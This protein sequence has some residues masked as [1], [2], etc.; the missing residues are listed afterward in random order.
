MLERHPAAPMRNKPSPPRLRLCFVGDAQSIHTVR[1]LRFFHERGHSVAVVSAA[2]LGDDFVAAT[3]Y[4]LSNDAPIPGTRILRNVFELRRYVTNFDPDVLH[5]HYINEAGWLA[6]LS[7]FHPFVLTAWGSDVYIAPRESL[8]AKVMTPYAVRR[9][10]FVTA[11]SYDQIA[12]LRQMGARQEATAVVCWGVD[13]SDFAGC[14]RENWRRRHG[15]GQDREVILSPR[16][17][18]T[19]SNIPVILDAFALVRR[20]RPKAFLVL[21]GAPSEDALIRRDIEA[22]ARALGIW[23]ATLVAHVEVAELP[24]LYA[25]A[26]I[27]VS[28][29]SSDGTPVSVLEA[30]AARSAVIAG[31]LPSLREWVTDGQTGLLVPVS[32]SAALATQI[33]QLLGDVHLRCRMT[34][35]AYQL[36]RTRGNRQLQLEEVERNYFRLAKL[37]AKSD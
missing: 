7:G 2:S 29:C 1:W 3:S 32:N 17:W 30:M 13:L 5:A 23:G 16:R 12:V 26:D 34:A 19:N 28:V 37:C 14:S 10:D 36:V 4:R 22:R 27:T 20:Y 24:E 31:D 18:V 11:D 9:A 25:A 8:L 21:A 15:V 6:A 35:A 33:V